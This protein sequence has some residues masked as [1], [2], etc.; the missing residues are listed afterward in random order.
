MRYFWSKKERPIRKEQRGS[1]LK[2]VVLVGNPNVGKSVL[3][4]RMT[5]LYAAVSNYPGTTV[6][7][8]RGRGY[9]MGEELEVVDTPGMYSLLSITAEEKVARKLLFMERPNVVIHVVDGRHLERM[10]SLTLQLLEAELPLIVAVNLMDE[11]RRLGLSLRADRLSRRLKAPVI[12]TAATLNVGID[13][14][15]KKVGELVYKAV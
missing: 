3:F 5:G 12:L 4:N 7:V 11:M 8:S 6:E 9:F 1:S 13:E 2:K 10:L 15:K 14:L